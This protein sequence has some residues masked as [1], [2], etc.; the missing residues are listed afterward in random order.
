[1][2][3]T[4]CPGCCFGSVPYVKGVGWG[5]GEI[6]GSFVFYLPGAKNKLQLN[7]SFSS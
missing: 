4:P 6:G 2:Q 1:M 3:T 5:K 7:D